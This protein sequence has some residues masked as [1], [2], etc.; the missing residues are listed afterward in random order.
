M[1]EKMG[2]NLWFQIR[3]VVMELVLSLSFFEPHKQDRPDRLNKP[4]ESAA[5]QAEKFGDPKLISVSGRQGKQVNVCDVLR[6]SPA[7]MT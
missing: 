1:H 7:S 6:W 5:R 3:Y 2:S 4:E